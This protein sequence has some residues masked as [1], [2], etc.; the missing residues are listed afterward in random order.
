MNRKLVFMRRRIEN[1]LDELFGCT[2]DPKDRVKRRFLNADMGAQHAFLAVELSILAGPLEGKRISITVRIGFDYPYAPPEVYCHDTNFHHP[3]RNPHTGLFMFSAIDP[4]YWKP[5]LGLG[6]VLCGLELVLI[7]P[8][9]SYASIR[10]LY[11]CS[12]LFN[13]K[14]RTS[15]V[16]MDLE[17]LT[18][19]SKINIEMENEIVEQSTWT[20]RPPQRLV[21]APGQH[22][23]IEKSQMRRLKIND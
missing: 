17:S 5:T 12:M 16:G 6:H 1:D 20:C 10:N 11:A 7:T 23:E 3:N 4:K 2:S 21:E 19:S 9:T 13:K 15:N 14:H 8:E 22:T 18:S